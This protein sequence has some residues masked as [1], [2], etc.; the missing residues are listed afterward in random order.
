MGGG[1]RERVTSD[2]LVCLKQITRS[3]PYSRGRGIKLHFWK[4]RLLKNLWI[5]FKPPERGMKKACG[6]RGERAVS[7]NGGMNLRLLGK[8]G[9]F[10]EN[11][12]FSVMI[13]DNEL[14]ESISPLNW[15]ARFEAS[16]PCSLLLL[17]LSDRFAVFVYLS[18][19][20]TKL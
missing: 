13:C 15:L 14:K 20:P 1:R 16:I 8:L 12:E 17:L 10:P 7:E 11:L 9:V 3:S 18:V 5:Y 6:E 19:S 2:V 4:G